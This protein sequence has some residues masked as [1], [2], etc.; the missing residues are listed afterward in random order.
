M[1]P[2]F[3]GDA[4]HRGD[5]QAVGVRGVKLAMAAPAWIDASAP[6]WLGA[7]AASGPP[8]RQAS[9]AKQRHVRAK[10]VQKDHKMWLSQWRAPAA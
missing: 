6:G 2:M 10:R 1:P 4:H 3:I 8:C 7:A 5:A 9:S